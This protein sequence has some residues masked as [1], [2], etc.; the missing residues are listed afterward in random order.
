MGSLR[1]GDA[2]DAADDE[3]SV[4]LNGG[5]NV[6]GELR[7]QPSRLMPDGTMDASVGQMVAAGLSTSATLLAAQ[8]LRNASRCWSLLREGC[9]ADDIM[10]LHQ[11][12]LHSMQADFGTLARLHAVGAAAEAT[13]SSAANGAVNNNAY[14]VE[15]IKLLSPAAAGDAAAGDAEAAE[16]AQ[17]AKVAAEAA[18]AAAAET[19]DAASDGN[20]MEATSK[21]AVSAWR[22]SQAAAAAAAAEA[23]CLDAARHSACARTVAALGCAMSAAQAYNA[24]RACAADA[25]RAEARAASA[26]LRAV[27]QGIALYAERRDYLKL[28]EIA[29]ASDVAGKALAAAKQAVEGWS[30]GSA[31]GRT[32]A[33]EAAKTCADAAQLCHKFMRS[34][35]K[36]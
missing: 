33:L 26:A 5:M 20:A 16:S 6:F 13:F 27:E 24:A 12:L 22:A 2:T 7:S 32:V 15:D 4:A 34:V 3:A 28:K 8:L 36:N 9:S 17:A 31:T 23:A 29:E 10:S 1:G 35:H 25:S 21:A 30:A 14:A 19:E 11:P 18:A